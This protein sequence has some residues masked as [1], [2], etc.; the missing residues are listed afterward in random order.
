M[1]VSITPN[2]KY[3]H[4]FLYLGYVLIRKYYLFPYSLSEL[5]QPTSQ[6]FYA[7]GEFKIFYKKRSN[8]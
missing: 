8:I 1:F 2:A 3:V 7:S 4:T 6:A 5:L